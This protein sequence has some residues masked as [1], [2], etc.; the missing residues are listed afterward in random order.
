MRAHKGTHTH[1]HG[2]V[3]MAGV[4]AVRQV[5]KEAGTDRHIDKRH[6]EI[7]IEKTDEAGGEK[8]VE[9]GD[10]REQPLLRRKWAERKKQNTREQPLLS[11]HNSAQWPESFFFFFKML[12]CTP[13]WP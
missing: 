5:Q 6:R 11:L 7:E 13:D 10:T 9:A 2:G 4:N 12:L 3:G 8:E 1:T